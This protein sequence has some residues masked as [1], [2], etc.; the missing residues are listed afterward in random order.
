[1]GDSQLKQRRQGRRKQDAEIP[2][3]L[4]VLTFP[5]SC[6]RKS[7]LCRKSHSNSRNSDSNG[8]RSI[9]FSW[10]FVWVE[11]AFRCWRCYLT[12]QADLW[13]RDVKS[14]Y[15]HTHEFKRIFE[16]QESGGGN[17][18]RAACPRACLRVHMCSGARVHI[19][20]S[21][22]VNCVQ[23]SSCQSRFV[24]ILGHHR[25]KKKPREAALAGRL[26]L[27]PTSSEGS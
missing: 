9:T 21:A 22:A 5:A 14:F 27:W 16:T 12:H 11:P 4:R 18:R 13:S 8:P 10:W 26:C 7:S 24:R 19:T 15:S 1:M 2:S 20:Q 3:A 23:L 17:F 6:Q 25:N